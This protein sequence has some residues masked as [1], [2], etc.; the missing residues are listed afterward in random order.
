MKFIVAMLVLL[1]AS[2]NADSN[3]IRV[4]LGKGASIEVPKNWVPWSANNKITLDAYV[5]SQG[6]K[7]VDSDLNFAANSYNDGGKTQAS[8]NARF[9]PNN[10]LTQ[11]FAKQL[12]GENLSELSDPMIANIKKAAA[13]GGSEFVSWD[14]IRFRTINSAYVLEHV[15]QIRDPKVEKTMVVIGLRVWNAPNSFTVTIAYDKKLEHL[16]KP[17]VEY[18]TASLKIKQ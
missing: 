9:Y 12:Y 16:F 17:I 14:S 10:T 15:H 3:F 18:M 8:I 1:V 7:L 5:E 13:A 2:A 11:E 4:P 6:Y